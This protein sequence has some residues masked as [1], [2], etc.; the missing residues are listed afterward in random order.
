MYNVGEYRRK[1]IG[2]EVAHEFWDPENTTIYAKRKEI[3]QLCLDD[4]LTG[5]TEENQSC[6]IFDAT[7]ATLARRQMLRE[8]VKN[9]DPQI[10]ILFIECLVKDPKL[11]DVMIN[12]MTLNSKGMIYLEYEYD[13]E[14]EYLNIWIKDYETKTAAEAKE[15]YHQRI[16]H[17]AS[18]YE[19][20]NAWLEP[21]SFIQIID[22]GKQLFCNQVYGYLQSRMMLFLANIRLHPRPIWFTRHGQSVT[23][24]KGRIG[25]DSMLS[26][27]GT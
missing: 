27:L 7:N 17:Y 9:K 26:P 24:V 16:R 12:E 2:S 1:L 5:L 11:V 8:T 18:T 21:C 10:G 15:D 3:A 20:L 6:V 4:A 22:A 25:G 13:L 14:Y 23:N 19:S